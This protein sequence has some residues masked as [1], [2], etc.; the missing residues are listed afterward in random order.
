MVSDQIIKVLDNLCEKF[1]LAIDW[2]SKNIQPYLE[3]LMAK[4]VNYKITMSI[5]WLI[6]GIFLFIICCLGIKI[7]FICQKKYHETDG[8]NEW[9]FAAFVIF[10][11][12][13]IGILCSCFM[14][15]DN[16]SMMI[17]CKTFPE[18]IVIDMIQ[19]YLASK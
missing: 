18:K 7:G 8:Y 15:F 2:S 10:L 11:S 13:A 5:M 12:S 17:T 3:E 16:I 4:A 1:G 9:D 14:I 19:T 6:S